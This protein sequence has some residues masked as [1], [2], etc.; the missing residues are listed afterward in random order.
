VTA[1]CRRQPGP[2]VG[3]LKVCAVPSCQRPDKRSGARRAPVHGGV[4]QPAQHRG[5]REGALPQR[6]R[7]AEADGDGQPDLHARKH[8]RHRRR[9]EHGQVKLVHLR[10]A[11]SLG[12]TLCEELLYVLWWR[13]RGTHHSEC[14][15]GAVCLQ[16]CSTHHRG[17]WDAASEDLNRDAASKD[18]ANKAASLADFRHMARPSHALSLARKQDVE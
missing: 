10:A 6:E 15:C 9:Q 1:P 14:T 8:D 12:T 16:I 5:V 13:D 2:L 17:D 18:C 3:T 7:D 11:G 4:R